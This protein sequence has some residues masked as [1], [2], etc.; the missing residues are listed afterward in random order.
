MEKSDHQRERN[1]FYT[2]EGERGAASSKAQNHGLSLG[3]AGITCEGNANARVRVQVPLPQS[4][5]R[6]ETFLTGCCVS[7]P[8]PLEGVKG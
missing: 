6:S 3:F 5:L 8:P 1:H 7:P 2:Q 4:C